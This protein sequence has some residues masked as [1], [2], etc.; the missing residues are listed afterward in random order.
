MRKNIPFYLS[1]LAVCLLAYAGLA[2]WM[3]ETY[4]LLQ[5]DSFFLF[6]ADY[7]YSK[8]TQPPA[9]TAWLT[10]LLLQL[11]RWPWMAALVQGFVAWLTVVCLTVLLKDGWKRWLSLL[12]SLL[13]F[14]LWS[15][16]LNLQ[17]QV[18]VMS[19]LLLCYCK[20]PSWWGRLI[21]VVVLI[22]LGYLLLSLPLLVALLLLFALIEWL[23]HKGRSHALVVALLALCPFIL[24]SI[25]SQRIA[26][27]PFEKRYTSI[28]EGSPIA[29]WDDVLPEQELYLKTL[30]A[31]EEE[32]WN[33]VRSIIYENGASHKK[34]MQSY[35]LLAEGAQGTLPDNLFKYNINNPEDF[36]YRHE[37]NHYT[38]QFNRL[39]YRSLGMYDECFHQAQEYY[40]LCSDACCFGSLTRMVDYSIREGEYAVAEKYLKILSRAPFYGHFVEEQSER[41]ARQKAEATIERPLRA[42]NFVGGYPFCSE[43]VRLVEYTEGDHNL[44]Y[45][46]LLCGLLLQKNLPHFNA[47][48]QHLPYHRADNLPLPCAQA[49]R[50]LQTEGQVPDEECV[51]GSY[52]YFFRYVSIPDPNEQ[53]TQSAGH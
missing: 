28:P 11:F 14:L 16:S 21:C 2:W 51:P 44:A 26:F 52:Y 29:L 25:Y 50:L 23:V 34:L 9:L 18:L 32:R 5:Y 3:P 46:Y 1:S 22:P 30:R 39:F 17:L 35:L 13:L 40:L 10:S 38:C 47:V 49:L 12:P 45:D 19:I 27:I 42:D 15:F 48:L 33:D 4:R 6:T 24:P 20:L 53:M 43:M 8:F 7:F 31:A 37:R 36:F 41:I